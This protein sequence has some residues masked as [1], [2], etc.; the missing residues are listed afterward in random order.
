[1]AELDREVAERLNER[2]SI[3]K[4]GISTRLKQRIMNGAQ[5]DRQNL[6]IPNCANSIE[7]LEEEIE[8]LID[9]GYDMHAVCM[10]VR[11]CPAMLRRAWRVGQ[12]SAGCTRAQRRQPRA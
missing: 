2:T 4:I 3:K 1:M 9:A 7:R 12:W 8:N 5:K 10:C 6:I 11:T